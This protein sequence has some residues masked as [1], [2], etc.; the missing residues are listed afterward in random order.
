LVPPRYHVL[1]DL[2]EIFLCLHLAHDW[3]LPGSSFLHP[4]DERRGQRLK[5]SILLLPLVGQIF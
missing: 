2:L 5:A 3:C 1:F 4:Y